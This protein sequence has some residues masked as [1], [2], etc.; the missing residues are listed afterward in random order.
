M[1]L[2]TIRP[3]AW[4]TRHGGG[5]VYLYEGLTRIWEAT[6]DERRSMP[7]MGT[8]GYQFITQKANAVLTER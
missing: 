8:W 6:H 3:S 7:V 4:V 5:T 1:D 2:D